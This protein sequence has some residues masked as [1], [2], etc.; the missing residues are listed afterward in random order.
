MKLTD[1]EFKMVR[2]FHLLTTK[3]TMYI[4]NVDEHGFEDNPTS[5]W[6]RKS[7]KKK[8][9]PVVAVCSKLESEIVELE[10]DEKP[11]SSPTSAWKSRPKTG[12]FAPAINYLAYKPTSPQVSKR[13][14][15][16]RLKSVIKHHEPPPQSTPIS[17][18]LHP[19]RSYFPTTLLPTMVNTR[20]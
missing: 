13:F 4:A 18:R 17:K 8:A 16:G 14:A 7:L 11:N 9:L 19:R 15:P 10:D 5:K 6:C 12:S 3:P 1:D 20:C 2:K